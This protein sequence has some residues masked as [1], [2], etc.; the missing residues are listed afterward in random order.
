MDELL[1]WLHARDVFFG[2][3]FQVQNLKEGLRLAGCSVHPDA[4]WLCSVFAHVVAGAVSAAVRVLLRGDS[5]KCRA[6]AGKLSR[7]EGLVRRAAEE[8]DLFALAVIVRPTQSDLEKLEQA[9]QKND[10]CEPHGFFSLASYY[11][12]ETDMGKVTRIV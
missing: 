12:R 7:D 8:G 1:K 4:V 9:A 2:D 11:Y 10:F 6:F 3:N 5:A